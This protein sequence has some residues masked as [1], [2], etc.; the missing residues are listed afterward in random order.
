M[1]LKKK[2]NSNQAAKPTDYSKDP[3]FVKKHEMAERKFK[4][5]ILPK[6]LL[7]NKK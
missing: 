5:A 2:N 6:E 4:K 3:F 7:E 1:K